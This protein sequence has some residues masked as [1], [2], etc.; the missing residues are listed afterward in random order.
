MSGLISGLTDCQLDHVLR[1]KELISRL[2]DS[3]ILFLMMDETLALRL[4]TTIPYATIAALV[5]VRPQFVKNIN[6][7]FPAKKLVKKMLKTKDFI[8][9]LPT[10]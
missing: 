6:D 2:K 8:R 9:L 5:Q 10:E 4:E 3:T 1:W 7:D